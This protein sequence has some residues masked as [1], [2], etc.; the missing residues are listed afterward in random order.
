MFLVDAAYCEPPFPV[1]LRGSFTEG[2][3]KAKR[4]PPELVAY[5]RGHGRKKVLFGT[6]YP[7]VTAA[8]CLE[9]F[10]ALG[11]GEEAARLFLRDNTRRVFKLG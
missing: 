11:L 9:G 10:D 6:N 7:M 5:M 3:Y 8:A 4:Y 2:G 1:T